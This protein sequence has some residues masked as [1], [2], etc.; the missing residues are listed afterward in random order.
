MIANPATIRKNH[1]RDTS[2]YA[3]IYIYRPKKVIGFA[4]VYQIYLDNI[5]AGTMKNN[6][7]YIFKVLR[8]GKSEIQSRAPNAK[9]S[10][11]VEIKFGQKYYVRS[12]VY[13]SLK[14]MWGPTLDLKEV[15][16]D[17]GEEDFAEVDLGG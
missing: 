7:G 10:L 15:K 6:T 12:T 5:L 9:A 3:I 14:N 16:E 11:R 4:A 2:Q 13:P 1:F 17:K 8:E